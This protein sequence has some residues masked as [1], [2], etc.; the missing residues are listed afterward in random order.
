MTLGHVIYQG[1]SRIDGQPIAVIVTGTG[2]RVSVNRKTGPMLQ[3]WILRTDVSPLR[4]LARGL[5]RS[6]CGDCIHASRASGGKGTCYVAVGR[7]PQGIWHAYQRGAYEISTTPRAIRAV[8]RG[9]RIRIGAYGDPGAAP[10][11]VWRALTA[12]ADGW[13]GYTHLWK[14][15][16]GLRGLVCAS[17]DSIEERTQ[18]RHSGWTTFRIAAI[19]EAMASIAGE[20][21]CPGSQGS[22]ICYACPIGCNGNSTRDVVIRAHGINA[23]RAEVA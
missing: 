1:P 8:G 21:V 4:A 7:A 17:V 23:P 18:A 15:R 10:L 9:R 2:S 16:P 11:H 12:E 14:Q 19:G 5:D 20:V 6:I 22:T 13:T 3:T